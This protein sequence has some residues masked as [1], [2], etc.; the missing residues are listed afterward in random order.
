[1]LG[2]RDA[3]AGAAQVW[4]PCLDATSCLDVRAL[5]LPFFK[6]RDNLLETNVTPQD[7]CFFNNDQLIT[8]I[9]LKPS[10]TKLAAYNDLK[11]SEFNCIPWRIYEKYIGGAE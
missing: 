4:E 6:W 2:W 8:N 9:S 10:I 3:D 5:G 7:F 1:M 11:D